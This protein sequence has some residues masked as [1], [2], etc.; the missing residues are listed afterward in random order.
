MLCGFRFDN[1]INFGAMF[2]VFR[3]YHGLWGEHIRFSG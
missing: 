3:L 1:V 2:D